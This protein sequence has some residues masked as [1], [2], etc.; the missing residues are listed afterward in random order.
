MPEE[1]WW[2]VSVLMRWGVYLLMWRGEIVYV[3]Q[4]VKLSARVNTHI[5]SKGKKRTQMLG[6]RQITGPVFDKVMVM[7]VPKEDLNRVE[8]ELI[9][10]Y[11]PRYNERH[12]NMPIPAQIKH[13]LSMLGSPIPEQDTS[14]FI[15]RRL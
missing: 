15:P 14:R 12:K 6:G 13:L 1:Q 7:F 2:D 10:R 9:E 4:S 3:G 5:Y 8:K 11:K